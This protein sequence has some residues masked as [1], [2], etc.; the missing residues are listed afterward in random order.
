MVASSRRPRAPFAAPALLLAAAAAA[1]AAWAPRRA[2]AMPSY[3]YRLP[4]GERVPCDAALG[5]TGCRPGA[6]EAHSINGPTPEHV[7]KGLGHATCEGGDFPLNLFGV[8][9]M[10]AGY[11][12]TEELCRKDSDGDGLTNGEELG[13]PCCV[14]EHEAL[15]LAGFAAHEV[16]HPG[17]AAS[18]SS[19]APPASCGGARGPRA[20]GRAT[21]KPDG[22]FFNPGED[23]RTADLHINGF[24]VPST[25]TTY[26]SFALDFPH[27]CVDRECYLVGMEAL[28]DQTTLVHHYVVD[29]CTK[30][31]APDKVGELVGWVISGG[32]QADCDFGGVGTWAPG[33]D[34][35]FNAPGVAGI[36]FGGPRLGYTFHGFF[37][38]MHY[39]NVWG[40][41]GAIDKS[42][43]RVHYVTTPREHGLGWIAAAELSYYSPAVMIPPKEERFHVTRVCTVTGLEEPAHISAIWYHAHLIGKEFST[44]LYRHGQKSVLW[45]ETS[46]HF[47]DQALPSL[48]AAGLTVYNGDQFVASCVYNSSTRDSNTYLN[49]ETTDEMCWAQLQYYPH[50]GKGAACNGVV[51]AGALE[52][53]EDVSKVRVCVR[54]LFAVVCWDFTEWRFMFVCFLC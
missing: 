9:F 48:E 45:R 36:P 53:G 51:F 6:Q 10:L 26:V 25:R 43:I 14:W 38:Q 2:A 17:V 11:R 18:R 29:G 34:P 8:D 3:R 47:D 13:D 5:M 40:V 46:W 7:C 28:V 42:G 54:A 19:T 37:L 31:W 39:D 35:M 22:G 15:P 33:A 41:E 23:A 49:L 52:P 21:T 16:S 12:W 20:A 24:E 1:A 44:E 50:V 4:N 27:D 30:E 32:G